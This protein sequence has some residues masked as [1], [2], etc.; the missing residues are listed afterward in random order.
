MEDWVFQDFICSEDSAATSPGEIF[1]QFF[2]RVKQRLATSSDAQTRREIMNCVYKYV[3]LVPLL[4]QGVK[5]DESA[6]SAPI[7]KYLTLLNSML[8]SLIVVFQPFSTITHCSLPP[9]LSK[10][11]N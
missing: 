7:A 3:F 8:L 6:A 10:A 5:L 1:S 2:L 9:L 4:A 11:A